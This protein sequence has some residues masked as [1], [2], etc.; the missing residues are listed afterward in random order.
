MLKGMPV[1]LFARAA[2]GRWWPGHPQEST[3]P[4]FRDE[5][6]D[7]ERLDDRAVTLAARFTINPRARQEHPAAL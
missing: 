5:L 4:P 3:D 7:A 2:A 1:S 6:L